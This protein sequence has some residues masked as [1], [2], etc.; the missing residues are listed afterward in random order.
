MTAGALSPDDAQKILSTVERYYNLV[1]EHGGQDGSGRVD[2][3]V[4][5]DIHSGKIRGVSG[6]WQGAKHRE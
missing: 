1:L 2:I 3:T 4:S 5:V 6:G